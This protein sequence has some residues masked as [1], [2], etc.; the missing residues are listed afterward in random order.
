MSC[1]RRAPLHES[2]DLGTAASAARA[3]ARRGRSR[4]LRLAKRSSRGDDRRGAADRDRCQSSLGLQGKAS[5]YATTTLAFVSEH[6]TVRG[7]MASHAQTA[8]TLHRERAA[9]GEPSASPLR[10]FQ[11]GTERAARS[12]GLTPQWYLLLSAGERLRSEATSVRPSASSPAGCTCAQS[13]VTELVNRAERAGSCAARL[14]PRR[15][16][17]AHRAQRGNGERAVRSSP[18]APS[19]TSDGPCAKRWPSW[20]ASPPSPAVHAPLHPAVGRAPLDSAVHTARERHAVVAAHRHRG[21]RDFD[22]ARE[23]L[24]LSPRQ[25]QDPHLG[26]AARTGAWAD[27]RSRGRRPAG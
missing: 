22:R 20:A 23:D 18:S 27:D 9:G 6:D 8:R 17:R 2:I 11:R 1:V 15:A 5:P 21:P 12:A 25:P 10:A 26:A 24:P 3:C 4:A 16:R 7:P 13:T 19:R 14:R